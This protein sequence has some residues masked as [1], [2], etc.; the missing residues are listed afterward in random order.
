MTN[1]LP[2]LDNDD[3]H[4]DETVQH[5]P[6]RPA[7]NRQQQR[8]Q[9]QGQPPVQRPPGQT[10][11]HNVQRV[12]RQRQ[13][14][15]A[16]QKENLLYFPLWSLGLML[17][18]VLVVAFAIVF[19][20]IA[21]GGNQA[22]SQADPVLRVITAVATNTPNIPD[23]NEVVLATS[24]IPADLS[25]ILPAQTPSN[26]ALDGPAL[27]TIAFTNTPM[28]LTVGVR[29]VVANVGDQE[30]NVRNVAGVTTSEVLFRSAEGTEFSII[31]GPQQ[32]DGFTWWRIQDPTT[33][34][35]GWA[36]ANYLQVFEAGTGQ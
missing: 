29:V 17:L 15:R 14:R 18:V 22:T 36:V 11:Q 30:L 12:S 34:Q 5:Q 3:S 6:Q 33:Q 9:A 16:A 27:P 7:R 21:L 31:D 10:A 19:G 32:A 28:P 8:Q 2:P 20:I 25:V 23:P 24:T 26:L 35:I 13:Q 1:Q 4:F